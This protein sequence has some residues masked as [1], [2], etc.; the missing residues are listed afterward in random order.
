LGHFIQDSAVR[1]QIESCL[2]PEIWGERSKDC[3]IDTV[4]LHAMHA[5]V[6]Y[7]QAPFSADNCIQILKDY[8][9]SAHYLIE[10]NG[11]ILN[12]VPEEKK[13]WHAGVSKMPS[14]DN[15]DG[16]ND[17]SIGIE[18]IGNEEEAFTNEQYDALNYL[19]ADIKKRR[20]ITSAVG[21]QHI[22]TQELVNAGLRKDAKWDPGK[23]FDWKR[24]GLGT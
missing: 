20:K 17:F 9:V 22:A 10:R 4:V 2:L 11:K 15:R 3:V 23:M 7:P 18:L 19:L 14:P 8:D 1:M 21:H 24:V 6:V 13:A 16:V 12:L 5:G